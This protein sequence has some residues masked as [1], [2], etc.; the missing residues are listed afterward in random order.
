M[1]SLGLGCTSIEWGEAVVI[2]D[3]VKTAEVMTVGRRSW[4]EAHMRPDGER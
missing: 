1:R 4:A 2:D 3:E